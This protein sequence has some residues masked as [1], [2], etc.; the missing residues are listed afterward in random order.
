ME[1]SHEV[2][3][4]MERSHRGRVH[5]LGKHASL[6]GLRGFKSHPLRIFYNG[7]ARWGVSGAL[8]PQSAIAGLNSRQRGLKCRNWHYI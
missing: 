4:Y 8:Y 6:N 3:I 5:M 7:R 1:D 2:A